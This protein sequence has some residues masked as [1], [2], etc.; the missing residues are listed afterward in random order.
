MADDAPLLFRKVFGA[1]RPANKAAEE[2]L[3]KIEGDSPVRVRITRTTGNVRRMALYWVYLGITVENLSDMVEGGLLTTKTL[4]TKLKRD[5][6]LSKPIVSKRTGEIVGWDDDSIAF[7]KM[8]ENERADFI[9]AAIEKMSKW[10][11]CDPADL[12][13]EGEAQAA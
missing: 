7:D 6:G 10:L 4:H 1:L 13:R 3:A 11:G 9:D 2:A 8:P 5:L 12:R